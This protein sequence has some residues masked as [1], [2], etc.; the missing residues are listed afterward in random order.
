MTRSNGLFSRNKSDVF[1][2]IFVLCT[3][4]FTSITVSSDFI[5]NP[6]YTIVSREMVDVDWAQYN[7]AADDVCDDSCDDDDDPNPNI[8]KRPIAM[9]YSIEPNPAHELTDEIVFEGYGEDQDGYIVEYLW[10]SSID[11]KINEDPSFSSNILTPGM[12]TITFHVK[13]DKGLWSEPANMSLDI[14]ENIAPNPPVVAGPIKAKVREMVE[15][16]FITSDMN[17]DQVLY[18]VEWGDDTNNDWIGPFQSDEDVILEHVWDSRGSYIIR[19]K[20]KDVFGHESEWS[21]YAI[22]MSQFYNLPLFLRV[23]LFNTTFSFL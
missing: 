19:A 13:D 14:V 3:L 15:Y 16:H 5:K 23:F 21:T 17:G 2:L 1:V 6:T 18:F 20:A 7:F 9:I 12:H 8:N 4:I 11:G 10:N 22:S